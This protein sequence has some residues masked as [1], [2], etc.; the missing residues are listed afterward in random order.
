MPKNPLQIDPS[1]TTSIRRQFVAEMN[2]RFREL[3]GAI[4]KLVDEDDVFGLKQNLPITFNKQEWRFKEAD[5]KLL[6]FKRW[7]RQKVN[8]GV[9]SVDANGR[10]WTQKY[11]ESAYKRGINRS[12]MD[13]RPK[14]MRESL[15]FYTGKRRQFLEDAFMTSER[16]SKMRLL[17]TRT[18]E[19]LDGITSAM[20]QQMGRVLAE[21]LAHGYGAAQMA[22]DLNKTVYGLTKTRARVIARTEVIHAHAEGQLDAFEDLGVTH[23]GV[24]VEWL[25]TDDDK[26]C[27]ACEELRGVVMTIDEARGLIPRHP[28]CRCAFAPA[29]VGET[30]QG[31][32]ATAR[33]KKKAFN[34][35]IKREQ[36]TAETVREAKER[37]SWAGK[38]KNLST[39]E[40]D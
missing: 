25:V 40:I 2:N 37:T 11:V 12:Y 5:E 38:G 31:R 27:E 19:E 28:N 1:R 26:L 21:G 10:P 39:V 16:I 14:A 30:D 8:E 36:K 34:A 22:R 33:E 32:K 6:S 35:S 20:S 18:F 3:R 24:L 9:L 23:V 17:A 15:D 13:A 29:N 7:F 4:R